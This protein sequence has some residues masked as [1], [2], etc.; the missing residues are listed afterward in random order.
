MFQDLQ[1]R[2]VCPPGIRVHHGTLA[3]HKKQNSELQFALSSPG[4]LISPDRSHSPGRRGN[5]GLWKAAVYRMKTSPALGKGVLPSSEATLG[6]GKRWDNRM[7]TSPTLGKGVL[8]SASSKVVSEEVMW[9]ASLRA[10]RRLWLVLL[11][12]EGGEGWRGLS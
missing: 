5:T 12:A 3:L 4:T 11:L 7:K 8:P 10:T 9:E 6:S 2:R 1:C